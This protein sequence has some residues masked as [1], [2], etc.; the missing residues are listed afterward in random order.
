[1]R[2]AQL[3]MLG[4]EVCHQVACPCHCAD[5]LAVFLDPIYQDGSQRMRAVE[6][7][8]RRASLLLLLLRT[9]LIGDLL[10]MQL[11]LGSMLVMSKSL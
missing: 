10:L 6:S 1:M 9:L 11:L 8:K 2:Q 4:V 7:S 3:C 5:A